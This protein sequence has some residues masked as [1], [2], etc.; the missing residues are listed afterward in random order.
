MSDRDSLAKFNSLLRAGLSLQQAERASNLARL[1]PVFAEHYAFLKH[2]ME[3][4]GGSPVLAM[5]Q[6]QSVAKAHIEHSARLAS[7]SVAPRATAR[8]VLGLPIAALL[9]GQLLGLGS[10]SVFF[11]TPIAF[12]SLLLGLSLLTA[13]HWWSARILQK[14]SMLD[15]DC[16]LLLDGIA[17]C[18]EAGMT[19]ESAAELVAETFRGDESCKAKVERDLHDIKS[20]SIETG[21]ATADLIRE[22]ANE[23]RTRAHY[24][25]VEV[26]EAI[27]IKLLIPLGVLVLPAFVLIAVVPMAI[28]LLTER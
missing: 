4:T 26:A 23:N 11:Q 6:L 5:G 21:A 15:P 8:L 1:S 2:L 12:F 18:L 7:S 19:F 13:A 17:L 25:Q 20:L 24:R 9:L 28:S 14:G 16:N 22:Q 27:T 3:Q 10:I